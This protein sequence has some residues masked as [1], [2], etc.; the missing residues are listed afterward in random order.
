MVRFLTGQFHVIDCVPWPDVAL[1]TTATG[2]PEVTSVSVPVL[3][4]FHVRTPQ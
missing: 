3:E 1:E 2:E 4:R